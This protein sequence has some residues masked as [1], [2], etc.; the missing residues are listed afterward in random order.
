V[1][2][3]GTS[4]LQLTVGGRRRVVVLHAPANPKAQP[5]PLVV[6]LH[7]SGSTAVGQEAFSGMDAIADQAGF[8]VAYPQGAITSGTGFDWN[9]PGVPLF[10]GGSPAPGSADDLAFLTKLPAMLQRS[11]CID[12]RRVYATG[13][14]G[15]GRMASQLG[16]DA[17]GVYAAVAPVAGLRLPTPC[18]GHAEPVIAFHGTADPIDPYAGRGQAYWTYSVPQAAQ[19]WA[20]HDRCE[21]RAQISEHAGYSLTT[22]ADCADHSGVELYAVAGEG[23][24]WPGG[25]RMPARLTAVLGPQ[26][27]A[28]DA[29]TTMWQ[30]FASHRLG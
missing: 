27:N 28:I 1:G 7:G 25:P 17:P 16:C 30:F 3:S 20:A 10:G 2:P 8:V 18:P 22:Y 6:D 13:M 14:S 29:D 9:I 5:R 23:H 21:A 4:T 11:Y 19:R 12:P 15:G 26:S 24:E